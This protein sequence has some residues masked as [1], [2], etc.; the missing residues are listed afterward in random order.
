MLFAQT[1]EWVKTS[2]NIATCGI[3][4][5]AVKELGEIV[6]IELPKIGSMLKKDG[7][8]AVIESTKAAT[9]IYSPVSGVVVAVNDKLINNL[10]LLNQDPENEGWLIKVELSDALE[11]NDLLTKPKYLELIG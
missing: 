9:D 3:S 8:M 4:F 6:Y 1:H 5:F 2:E 11:L 7:E 10:G